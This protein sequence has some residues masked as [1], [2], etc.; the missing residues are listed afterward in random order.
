MRWAFLFLQT[1]LAN[2][3]NPKGDGSSVGGWGEEEEREGERGQGR[4]GRREGLKKFR[5][6][7]REG[8][9]LPQSGMGGSNFPKRIHLKE[10][11]GA[12]RG[13]GG[14]LTAE[15]RWR[16]SSVHSNLCDKEGGRRTGRANKQ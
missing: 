14:N 13:R 6:Q 5:L 4:R 7:Q 12:R 3:F 8:G 9:S 11:G 16:I 1:P 10:T 15:E 2:D